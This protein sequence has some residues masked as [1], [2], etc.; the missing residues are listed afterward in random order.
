MTYAS[1]PLA[2]PIPRCWKCGSRAATV[3]RFCDECA[4]VGDAWAT[5]REPGCNTVRRP[6]YAGERWFWCPD[7]A[8]NFGGAPS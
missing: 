1:L 8:Q 3:G 2:K 5:C 7:H 6:R 4:V